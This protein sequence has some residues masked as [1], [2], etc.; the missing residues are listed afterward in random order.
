MIFI[1]SSAAAT[2]GQ[3]DNVRTAASHTAG[4]ASDRCPRTAARASGPANPPNACNSSG[5]ALAGAFTSAAITGRAASAG[6]ES[7]APAASTAR[8][9]A[10]ASPGVGAA[11]SSSTSFA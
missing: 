9:A 8:C 5:F 10:A 6:L 2:S 1:R 3:A 11:T 4:S 7:R